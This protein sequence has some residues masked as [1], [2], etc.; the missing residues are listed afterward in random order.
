MR[1]LWGAVFPTED[2]P[3]A[4]GPPQRSTDARHRARDRTAASGPSDL[5][6]RCGGA[7]GVVNQ[8][9]ATQR[10][11][12]SQHQ[13]HTPPQAPAAR[14][15]RRLI[16]G[17]AQGLGRPSLHAA[18]AL[19]VRS[20]DSASNR[21][22]GLFAPQHECPPPLSQPEC[23]LQDA[24]LR[25][26]NPS[27]LPETPSRVGLTLTNAPLNAAIVHPFLGLSAEGASSPAP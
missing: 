4:G 24:C 13:G 16:P 22:P 17:L 1:K 26:V 20:V 11:A 27:T 21:C 3:K 23:P 25:H 14:T 8:A 10:T 7:A 15:P 5:P 6:A 19:P 9:V 2:L 12:T 18:A